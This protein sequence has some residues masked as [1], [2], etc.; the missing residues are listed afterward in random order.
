MAFATAHPAVATLNVPGSA[1]AVAGPRMSLYW[2]PAERASEAK[3]GS[4]EPYSS[5]ARRRDWLAWSPPSGELTAS[6][7]GASIESPG[8][9]R[10][11]LGFCDLR[12]ALTAS[13][14]TSYAHLTRSWD[15]VT[16]AV[17]LLFAAMKTSCS[18]PQMPQDCY[19]ILPGPPGLSRSPRLENFTRRSRRGL[20]RTARAFLE[21]A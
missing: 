4:T 14:R 16:G 13:G 8:G 20:E 3:H 1:S 10:Y 19:S 5:D 18:F 2:P 15:R 9:D 21:K 6:E 11:V 17:L 12:G 7:A